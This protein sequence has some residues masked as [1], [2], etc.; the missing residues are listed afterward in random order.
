M[1]FL[2]YVE[3]KKKGVTES[4]LVSATDGN[5]GYGLAHVGNLFN[6]QVKVR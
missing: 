5:H 1:L 2:S 6:L 3:A 4:V